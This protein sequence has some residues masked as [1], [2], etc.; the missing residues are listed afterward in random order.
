MALEN[1]RIEIDENDLL[2]ITIDLKRTLGK[3]KTGSSDV[4]ARSGGNLRL[5]D[6][7]GYRDEILNLSVSRRLPKPERRGWIL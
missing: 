5:F 3:S 4:V 1:L 2:H 7:R 6:R